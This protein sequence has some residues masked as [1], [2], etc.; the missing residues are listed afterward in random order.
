MGD[1]LDDQ[2][3][4]HS[5]QWG[6]WWMTPLSLADGNPL[7]VISTLMYW[8]ASVRKIPFNSS[9]PSSAK[10]PESLRQLLYI[11]TPIHQTQTFVNAKIGLERSATGTMTSKVKTDRAN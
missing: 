7:R 11:T 10:A 9:W 8:K 2:Q 4:L 3:T 6:N 5:P 1:A